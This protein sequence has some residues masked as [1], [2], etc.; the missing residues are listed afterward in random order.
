MIQ[1]SNSFARLMAELKKLPGVG[2]KS[3]FRLALHLLKL[4]SQCSALAEALLEAKEKI[5]FCSVCFALTE[6]NPCRF[7]TGE[8]DDET[9]CVVEEPRDLLAVERS[10]VYRGRYHVL[11]GALSPINGI[12]PS[13][14]RVVELMGRLESGTFKEVLL[15][16]NFTVEGE[17]TALYL[18]R[19]IKPLG[20]RVTRLAYGI[21]L[22]S[23]LEY[24][25]S[26][27]VQRALEGRNEL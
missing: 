15:A 14:L 8:R 9:L 4:P 10:G 11:H 26:V 23:D 5:G 12:T 3:A 13:R 19:Q 21:P 7:C 20:I 6:E 17:A 16:T 27:T 2:E 25:D 22:G 24:V 1:S 18:T